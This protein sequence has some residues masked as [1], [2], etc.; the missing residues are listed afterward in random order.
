MSKHSEWSFTMFNGVSFA[1][2]DVAEIGGVS[3]GSDG[4]YVVRDG[5]VMAARPIGSNGDAGAFAS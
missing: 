1:I 5:R 4:L 2:T 3:V